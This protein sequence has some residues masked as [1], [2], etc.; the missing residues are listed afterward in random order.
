[1]QTKVNVYE[2]LEKNMHLEVYLG[3]VKDYIEKKI[4]AYAK[5]NRAKS[6]PWLHFSQV[7]TEEWL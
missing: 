6:P 3:K 5:E 7:Y 1:M 4:L 2:H